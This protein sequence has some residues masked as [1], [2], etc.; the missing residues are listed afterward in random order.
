MSQPDSHA[1]IEMDGGDRVAGVTAQVGIPIK[2]VPDSV[3]STPSPKIRLAVQLNQEIIS[4]LRVESEQLQERLI[5][6]AEEAQE[7]PAITF[8]P[9]PTPAA[10]VV[11]ET[12]RTA[13]EVDE[14]W[15]IILQHWRPE[16]WEII[17][18]LCQKQSIQL[19]TT[20]RKDHRPVS[21]LI[22]E[23]NSPVDEQLGDLLIDPDTQT[24]SH[25]LQS[26][27]ESL[28]RWY[29]SSNLKGR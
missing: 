25:H 29:Q 4:K 18:L 28:V 12:A 23:I 2:T 6:E 10:P 7:Q 26:V 19:T 22:D 5:V 27:A 1:H 3:K 11:R 15:Q 20:E 16:H 8:M 13:L 17:S 21:R 9:D 14:D 24:I